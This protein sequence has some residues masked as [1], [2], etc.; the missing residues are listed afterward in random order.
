MSIIFLYVNNVKV[1]DEKIFLSVENFG[2]ESARPV[3]LLKIQFLLSIVPQSF[4]YLYYFSSEFKI[5]LHSKK[6][7]KIV[8]G[9]FTFFIISSPVLLFLSEEI[10]FFNFFNNVT[11]I[12]KYLFTPVDVFV[13]KINH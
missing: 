8:L 5:Y 9:L 10:F 1:L 7:S 11:K 6:A 13:F 4:F 12:L 3:L 2:H